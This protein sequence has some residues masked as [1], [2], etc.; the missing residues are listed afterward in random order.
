MAQFEHCGNEAIC[1]RAVAQ[2]VVVDYSIICFLK[3]NYLFNGCR[4]GRSKFTVNAKFFNM[5]H[6][7]SSI[8]NIFDSNDFFFLT[9]AEG[10]DKKSHGKAYRKYATGLWPVPQA[11]PQQKRR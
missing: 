11:V 4:F 10:V 6:N 3:I 5:A 7:D 9:G 2:C 8:Y 1:C